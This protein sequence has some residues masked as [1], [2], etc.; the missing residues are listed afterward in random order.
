MNALRVL[1]YIDLV[2]RT[3]SI[4]RAA[5]RLHISS[6]AVNRA[7]LALERELGAQLFERRQNGVRL[8]SAGEAYVLFARQTLGGLERVR[9]EME[10]LRGIR[11]GRIAIAAIQSVAGTL[12]AQAIA[13]FQARYPGVVFEVAVLGNDAILEALES[14]TVEL[15]IAFNP[16]PHAGTTTLAILEQSLCVVMADAHP[17]SG[18]TSLRLHECLEYRLAL[19]DSSRIGRQLMDTMLRRAGFRGAPALVSDSFELLAAWCRAGT[20]LC[21]Q[22][23]VGV[24][25]GTGLVAVPLQEPGAPGPLVVLAHRGRV[26][27]RQASAFADALVSLLHEQPAPSLRT[28]TP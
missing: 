28:P 22:I 14:D 2:A 20:G 5:E 4:R 16:P 21:F 13:A 27:T 23:G 1:T 24:P 11:R 15:G 17:L 19:A 25:Q 8:S 18:R 7:I 6:T 3:G 26:L 10:D 12:L 9:S